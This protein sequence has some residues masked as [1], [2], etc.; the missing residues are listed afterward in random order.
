MPAFGPWVG[1]QKE[2]QAQAPIRQAFDN[3]AAIAFVKPNSVQWHLLQLCQKL[4]YAH[5]IGLGADHANVGMV[6]GLPDEMLAS[7]KPDLQPEL[8]NTVRELCPRVTTRP[9]SKLAQQLSTEPG[10]A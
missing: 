8:L 1:E 2:E 6:F 4:G 9:V 5:L 7:P 10:L 3:F